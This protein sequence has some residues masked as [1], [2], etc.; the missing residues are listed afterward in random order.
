MPKKILIVIDMQNDF[1]AGSLGTEEAKQIVDAVKNKILSYDKQ[2][3]FATRD[4]H[5][6]DYLETQ[7]GKNLPVKHCILGTDGHKIINELIT[8]ID[9]KNIFN[10]PTFGSVE[11]ATK[12]KSIYDQN[13]GDIEIE[14]CGLCTDICVIS[15]A[16]MLKAFMPEVKI[17]L[18]EKCTAGVT[19]QLKDSAIKTMKSCQINIM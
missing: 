12:I 7:E 14:I 3:V 11:L 8:L 2:D 18:D 1:V 4:T 6:D 19:P 16:L 9:E 15:N 10:K 13:N 17:S 5:N